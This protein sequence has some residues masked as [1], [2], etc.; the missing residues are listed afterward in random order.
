MSESSTPSASSVWVYT[1]ANLVIL[2]ITI[3]CLTIM[4]GK[5]EP[6]ILAV[7]ACLLGY[8]CSKIIAFFLIALGGGKK[9]KTA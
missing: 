5:V 7:L 4:L 2:V 6:V 9:K 1:A 3:A 8:M